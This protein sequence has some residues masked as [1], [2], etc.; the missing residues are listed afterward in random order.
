MFYFKFK[1]HGGVV[2]QPKYDPPVCTR[3]KIR[4]IETCKNFLLR[5]FLLATKNLLELQILRSFNKKKVQFQ[6]NCELFEC[7]NYSNVSTIWMYE[8]SWMYQ[9]S[10]LTI[11]NVKWCD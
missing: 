10:W 11:C 6:N 7:I 1:Q 3:S 8:H 4:N 5:S 2:L 9:H